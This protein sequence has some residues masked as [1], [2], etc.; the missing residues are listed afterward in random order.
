[1]PAATHARVRRGG[2]L[3]QAAGP[4]MRLP[5]WLASRRRERFRPAED[6]GIQAEG[7]GADEQD[8]R[9]E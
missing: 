8:G 5:A 2:A 9:E 7:S 6:R 1:M 3:D 4:R